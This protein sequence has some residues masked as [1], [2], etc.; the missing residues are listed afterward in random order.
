MSNNSPLSAS[1]SIPS[2]NSNG[3]PLLSAF[4]GK[5]PTPTSNI[6]QF[7]ESSLP[8]TWYYT[9]TGCLGNGKTVLT[10]SI[11]TAMLDVIIPGNLTVEGIITSASD[12]NLKENIQTISQEKYNEVLK[13]EPK[14]YQFKND[15]TKKQHYGVIAQEL[16]TVFPE[17]VSNQFFYGTNKKHVDYLELIPLL[18][19]KMKLM[20][21]E[22]NELKT[23]I[24]NNDKKQ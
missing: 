5:I 23:M 16:E 20:Q 17:L 9:K 11:Q 15:S 19:G 22:I 21:E 6:K 3:A 18:I 12:V 4:G 24:K 1:G 10:T 2:L 14:L 8:A 7:Y 13:I